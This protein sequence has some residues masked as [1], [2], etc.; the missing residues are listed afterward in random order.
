[1]HPELATALMD[2]LRDECAD[3]ATLKQRL[4][5]LASLLTLAGPD[6]EAAARHIVQ[7][8]VLLVQASLLR[9]HAPQVLSDTFIHSRF[10]LGGRV[11]GA[12]P[13]P[14]A[15]QTVLERSWPA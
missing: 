2:S 9:R 10:H 14:L 15:L 7:E 13:A 6:Q 3:E 5:S 11:Y 4:A 1:R 8:L 12:W